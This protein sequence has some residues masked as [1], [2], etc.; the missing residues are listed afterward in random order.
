MNRISKKMVFITGATSGIGRATAMAYAKLGANLILAGRNIEVLKEIKSK[1]HE[2]Y[3]IK[4]HVLKF[5]VRDLEGIKDAVNNLPEEF[6]RI[7]ILINNAGLALGMNKIHESSFDSFDTIM[8]TNVKGLLYVTRVVTPYML[9]HSPE[10]HIVNIAST[11]AQ[12][13]YAG[14]GVYCASKAAVKTL[15][16]GMRIDLVDT[17]VRVTTINPGMVETNFSITRFDGDK[18]RADKV[19]DG[20]E[21]LTAEDVADT[22]IYATNL[23]LNVQICELT[24]TPN[25]Q[26]DGRT[27]YRQK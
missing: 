26:A 15:S 19:Y 13:A 3:D 17:P 21:P 24:L 11:A 22:I 16:D 14:G 27:S 2:W 20:I 25:H 4:V 10:G 6:K 5:D 1:L 7:D 8:D 18:K 12:A 9:E 23:P